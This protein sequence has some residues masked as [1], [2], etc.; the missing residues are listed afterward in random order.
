MFQR[1]TAFP[2]FRLAVLPARRPLSVK[3]TA[4]MVKELRAATG[5]PMMECK[6]ALSDPEVNGELTAAMD[7]LRK[8]GVMAATKKAGRVAGEGL[9]GLAVAPSGNA[10]AIVEVRPALCV[11]AMMPTRCPAFCS[12]DAGTT[13]FPA[14]IMLLSLLFV[15]CMC[16]WLCV[17]ASGCCCRD[18]GLSPLPLS[19]R[20][21]VRPTSLRATSCSRRWYDR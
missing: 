21:T 19:P 14:L 10:A 8:K 3:V 7:W 2:L 6:A 20:S 5:A 1:A 13:A 17:G 11:A 4:E 12:L 16:L 15:L 9:V 18:F